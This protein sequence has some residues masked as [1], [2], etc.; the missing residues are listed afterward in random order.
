MDSS[1]KGLLAEVALAGTGHHCHAYAEQIAD[2]LEQVEHQDEAA[3]LIRLSSLMNRGDY[4][5]ALIA[6]QGKEWPSLSPWLA[7]CEW[8]LGMGAALDRRLAQLA[9][10]D[11]PRLVQFAEGMRHPEGP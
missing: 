2:W 6:A 5:Q 8:R 9:Q 3:C 7:L 10:S 1:L 4:Q 11:D